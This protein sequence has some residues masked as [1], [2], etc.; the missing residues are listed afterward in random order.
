MS[1]VAG[2]R[3]YSAKDVPLYCSCILSDIPIVFNL[4]QDLSQISLRWLKRSSFAHL[5]TIF[6][7]VCSTA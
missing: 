7:L 5:I 1:Y 4:K 6:I 3:Y 2:K